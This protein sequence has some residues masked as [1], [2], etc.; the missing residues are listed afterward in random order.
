MKNLLYVIFLFLCTTIQAQQ[1]IEIKG[2]VI[3]KKT[4]L[5]VSSATI[6]VSIAKDS[7]MIDYTITNNS[8]NFLMNIKK[9]NTAFSVNASFVG[10][11][12]Q[13][14]VF[15]GTET[16]YDLGIL[17][18]AEAANELQEVILKGSAP[19][20]LIK[21][22]TLEFNAASF[23]T[24][25]DANVEALLKQLPGVE[26]DEEGKIT[27]NGKEVNNILVN[28]KPFFGKD[29]KIATQNL[30]AEIIEKVQVT[31]TKTK[32]EELSGEAAS[33]ENKTINL[34]IAEENN[35][36]QFGKIMGG[37]GSDERYESS[38]LYNRF[39]GDRK[40]SVLASSN[41]I[42]SIGFS[43]NEIF[44]NM[45]GGRSRSVY[46]NDNGSFGINNLR[47][48]AND[49]GITQSSMVGVNYQDKWLGKIDNQAS[50]FLSN[51]ETRNDNRNNTVNF[52]PTGTTFSE[53]AARTRAF[54]NGHNFSSEFEYKI[55]S[56]ASIFFSPSLAKSLAKNYS[57]RNQTT[58]NEA[59]DVLNDSE[60]DNDSR[61]ENDQFTGNFTYYKSFKRKQGLTVD[62]SLDNS[63]NNNLT[64]TASATT[65]ADRP[66]DIR[67]QRQFDN[68]KNNNFNIQSEFT[69]KLTDSTRY[70]LGVR[71]EL[72]DSKSVLETFDFDAGSGNFDNLNAAQSNDIRS[73]TQK[74]RPTAGIQWNSKKVNFSATVGAEFVN[75]NNESDYLGINT[76]LDK[77]YVFPDANAYL[78]YQFSEKKS[79][80][81]NYDYDVQLP[82]AQQIL[83][84][85]N[86]SDPLNT[87]IGNSALDPTYQHS[88]YLSFNNYDWAQR[89]GLF[90]Y[91][92]FTYST[93]S[94]VSSTVFDD[95]FKAVTT[96]D[97]V[98]D[99]YNFYFGGNYS[100]SYKKGTR[101]FKWTTAM[102][103]S[104]NFSRGLTNAVDFTN[105]SYRIS[106]RVNLS[107]TLDK[108]I[109]IMPS[110]NYTMFLNNY[111]NYI[112]DEANNFT[113]RAQLQFTSY[114][115]KNVIGGIDFSY[116]YN[117]NIAD[118]F[119][120]DF[121]LMNVSLGYEFW[122]K[123]LIAKVKVYDLLDQNLN[124]RRTITPTA[125]I[126]S[127]NTVLRRYV[128]F[129]L[130]YNLKSFG[131]KKD[132]GGMI[133]IH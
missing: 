117:S 18:L 72:L 8:G 131:D 39:K 84:V 33:S 56:T 95:S 64:Q 86:L 113:H 108:V 133:I 115:P 63:R 92:G 40:V 25:P 52:L 47:F 79:L 13:T 132:E 102:S 26:I 61:T 68:S 83:P 101:T 44:D 12:T 22:D 37:Y 71:Y 46:Y 3:D 10:Y 43:M 42:N 23:K 78:S 4:K 104:G 6:F 36:G 20:I 112:I 19:P 88:F 100:K 87:F 119:R 51:T 24:G 109:D 30:P 105:E 21:K 70:A 107:Y 122:K 65:F 53:S 14:K 59:G 91:S 27:V 106:P 124:A 49:T 76:E 103:M 29:G 130:T 114:V 116:N 5:P 96:Y 120:K 118:G 55:D 1:K 77:N 41:N 127:E 85:E 111:T 80:Y 126:D 75:F 98:G 15:E 62:A 45:G 67:N 90:T 38:L 57:S 73:N 82:Q 31:D 48:G 50:Y 66:D 93:N 7:S 121:Y 28:G 9:P 89:A 11:E 58:R 123:Q 81:V 110:Y 74:I 99:T 2:K 128:M 60:F 94:I 69:A 34:T 97:N 16:D 125:I 35:K 129:S 54:S 17:E 32:S